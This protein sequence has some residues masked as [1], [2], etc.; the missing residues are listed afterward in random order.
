MLKW[1]YYS[2]SFSTIVI[3]RSGEYIWDV[4]LIEVDF[5]LYMHRFTYVEVFYAL[6]ERSIIK[7]MVQNVQGLVNHV[8][9][10]PDEYKL[11]FETLFLYCFRASTFLFLSYRKKSVFVFGLRNLTGR[12]YWKA[13]SVLM[14]KYFLIYLT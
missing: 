9:Q 13:N 7:I 11:D 4:Y 8:L 3:L 14:L 10:S 12:K 2:L 1:I 5:D 6:I